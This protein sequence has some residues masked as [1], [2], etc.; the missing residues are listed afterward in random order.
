M[1]E[2]AA[3]FIALQVAAINA[4]AERCRVCGGV[5]GWAHDHK[6]DETGLDDGVWLPGHAP[7]K[8][9]APKSADE[10]KRIR[11]QAWDTRRKLLGPRGHR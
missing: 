3:D 4:G 8:T 10:M 2:P 7:R 5:L 11:A 9:P 1:A 6:H